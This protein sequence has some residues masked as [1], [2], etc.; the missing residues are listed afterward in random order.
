M[1]KLHP[2]R[3]STRL[4][5]KTP[6]TTYELIN[7]YHRLQSRGWVAHQRVTGY[8]STFS[9][10]HFNGTKTYTFTQIHRQDVMGEPSQREKTMWGGRGMFTGSV[11]IIE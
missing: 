11:N 9:S 3:E 8:I 6:T 4:L 1:N 2:Y 5:Y 10:H 7:E